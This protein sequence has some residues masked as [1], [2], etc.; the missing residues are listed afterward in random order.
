MRRAILLSVLGLALSWGGAKSAETPSTPVATSP[1]AAAAS[2]QA[3]LPAGPLDGVLYMLPANCPRLCNLTQG[4]SCTG[5]PLTEP[6]YDSFSKQCRT[7]NCTAN[8][9]WSCYPEA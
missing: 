2:F 7:C 1:A 3:A 4:T 8:L 5:N 9:V 6:C